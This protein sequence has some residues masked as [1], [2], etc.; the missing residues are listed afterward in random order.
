MLRA[1]LALACAGYGDTNKVT[2]PRV[3]EALEGLNVVKIASYNEHTAALTGT[4]LHYTRPCCREGRVGSDLCVH[5]DPSAMACSASPTTS[6]MSDMH[7]LINNPDHS[8][9]TF[10][11][12]GRA[13]YAHKAILAIRC[14]HFRCVCVLRY[15]H[16]SA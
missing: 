3:V 14:D 12:E 6:F 1:H 16:E 10:L 8:D 15:V 2:Q 13:V 9:I 5:A 7:R 11:V 4:H